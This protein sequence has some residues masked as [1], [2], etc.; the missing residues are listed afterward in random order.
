M[1]L[2]GRKGETQTNGLWCL[3]GSWTRCETDDDL[4][5]GL[6]EG[7]GAGWKSVGFDGSLLRVA[8]RLVKRLALQGAV[9]GSV[10]W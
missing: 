7:V 5:S 9:R 3:V 8:Q 6:C 4:H 1:S 10:V 2:K